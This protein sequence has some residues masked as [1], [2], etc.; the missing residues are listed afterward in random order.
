MS[1]YS[2]SEEE[3]YSG[4]DSGDEVNYHSSSGSPSYSPS[5]SGSDS[6]ESSESESEPEPES[7]SDS[8]SDRGRDLGTSGDFS[9]GRLFSSSAS[10][11]ASGDGGEEGEGEEEEAGP[12]KPVSAIREYISYSG[13]EEI[14]CMNCFDIPRDPIALSCGH[15]ICRECAKEAVDLFK[16]TLCFT[17]R[18]KLKDEEIGEG[19]DVLTCPVPSYQK[20]I[21]LASF[22][23]SCMVSGLPTPIRDLCDQIQ[24]KIIGIRDLD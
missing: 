7:D 13:V 5:L 14:V 12:E 10:F 23:T 22:V 24:R 21:V 17:Q 1:D 6:P 19:D 3:Y 11:G 20:R 2:D 18:Y 16:A 4:S 8:D 15:V 9:L